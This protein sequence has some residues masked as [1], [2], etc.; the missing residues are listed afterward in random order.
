MEV[1]IREPHRTKMDYSAGPAVTVGTDERRA[2]ADQPTWW[3]FAL[4]VPRGAFAGNPQDAIPFPGGSDLAARKA[5]DR[6]AKSLCV[7]C[8]LVLRCLRSAWETEE[9]GLFGG[10]SETERYH[11]GGRGRAGGGGAG[12]GARTPETRMKALVNVAMRFGS[13]EHPVVR[14]LKDQPIAGDSPEATTRE[15]EYGEEGV[16]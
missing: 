7:T 11:L 8:P 5:A 14:W 4:P 6:R 16:A 2:C 10:V 1:S 13:T 12:G 15:P 9:Y 3:W